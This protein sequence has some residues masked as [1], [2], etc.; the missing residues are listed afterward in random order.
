M[1]SAA[2][3]VP[4]DGAQAFAFVAPHLDYIRELRLTYQHLADFAWPRLP[5]RLRLFVA[6]GL[7]GSAIAAVVN[8][9]STLYS[10]G[11]DRADSVLPLLDI[12][13]KAAIEVLVFEFEEGMEGELSAS[14]FQG[15]KTVE[16]VHIWGVEADEVALRGLPNS[17][18]ELG[19]DTRIDFATWSDLLDDPSWL[20]HLVLFTMRVEPWLD[21]DD[22]RE[23]LDD[24]EAE[25]ESKGIEFVIDVW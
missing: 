10:L 7:P 8:A 9:S 12:A 13:R 6:R 17:V 18:C 4:V 14:T 3:S 5:A 2:D 23:E 20:P 25:V 22:W 11:L 16:K 15:F 1:S 24:L 21:M 19:A